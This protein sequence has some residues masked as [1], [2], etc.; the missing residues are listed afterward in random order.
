MKKFTLFL[1][2][3]LY[4][5]PTKM[6]ATGIDS[7]NVTS[8]FVTVGEVFYIDYFTNYAVYSNRSFFKDEN[9]GLHIAFISNYE[10]K[11][12][13]SSD[14]GN[15]WTVE[16]VESIYD[17]D[18]KE[19]VIYA[20][21]DGNPHIAAT[22][23][24][25]FDYGNPTSIAYGQEFR[26]N[27]A[28]FYKNEGIWMEDDV[29]ISTTNTGF[30]GNYGMRVCEIYMNM[31]N[32]MVIMGSRYGWYTYGGEIWEFFQDSEGTW[33][34]PSIVYNYN[35]T[36]V[37]HTLHYVYSILKD[38]GV[39]E[40]VYCRPYNASGMAELVT[41]NNIGGSWSE[42]IQL[43]TDL[44]NYVAWDLS[45]SAGED[46]YLVYFSNEPSP[47]VNMYTDLSEEAIE[48]DIDLSLIDTIQSVKIHVTKDELLDL[49]VYP[50]NS[51]T[52]FLFVSE[53][54]G[55]TWAAPF[56]RERHELTGILPSTDQFSSQG[57]DFEMAYVKRI[58]SAEPYGPDSLFYRHF[59]QV[60]TTSLG[61]R[62]FEEMEEKLSFYPNPFTDLLTVEY[63]LQANSELNVK[64]YNLQ[65]KVVL[66]RNYNGTQ[67]VTTLK[68]DLGYLDAGTYLLEVYE[69]DAANDGLHRSIQKIMKV[70]R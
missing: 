28:Y 61:L 21:G 11:Y 32:E 35:D 10:L 34:E 3:I 6:V 20:D 64:V 51:D 12:C 27:V 69:I 62:D 65:G 15:T 19:A 18:F 14:S 60:N 1:A 25:Y 52:A 57:S 50:L 38:T 24:P 48:L 41:M 4:L 22:V 43:T 31:E 42:P 67:G 40:L 17:G 33:S 5:L 55:E 7:L 68:L 37:D 70:S 58:P 47:H 53:D 2:L 29:F 46:P 66:D 56:Y 49:I 16:E 26:Y 23:N 44:Y 63:L 8:K 45:V 9:G 54:L 59:E 36:P 13:F 39:R 30:S